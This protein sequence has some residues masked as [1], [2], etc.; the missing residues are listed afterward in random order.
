MKPEKQEQDSQNDSLWELI[1]KAKTHE[2]SPFFARNVVREIRETSPGKP[3]A[4]LKR[5]WTFA[6]TGAFA[7]AIAAL[8]TVSE[9]HSQTGQTGNMGNSGSVSPTP[10][11]AQITQNPD[12]DVIANLDTLV[13]SENNS[14]WLDHSSD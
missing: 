14:I 7:I 2:A 13:A 1:G 10:S 9:F 6:A 3:F 8:F 11:I 12:S 4:W 5:K